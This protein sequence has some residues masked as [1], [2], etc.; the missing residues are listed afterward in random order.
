MKKWVIGGVVL[1]VATLFVA[2]YWLILAIIIIGPYKG[3]QFETWQSQN[4]SFQIRVDA[5]HEA[6]GGF[7]PGAYYTFFSAPVGSNDWKEVMT[8]RHD[9]PIDIRKSQV[10]FVSDGVG[11]VYM[12][13][14]FASTNDGGQS[15]TVWDA[16][17]K[18]PDLKSCNY[19]GIKAVELNS[20]GKGRMTVDPIPGV[21]PLPVLR[22]DDFGR[23]WNK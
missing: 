14:M 12:G 6:N 7:V 19:E 15:W 1:C 10:Q 20:D 8:F 2:K 16:C 21:S 11:F 9:D 13:W 5:F 3:P 22:T 23:S 4:A 18:A 17:K